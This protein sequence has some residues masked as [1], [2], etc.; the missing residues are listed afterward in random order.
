MCIRDRYYVDSKRAIMLPVGFAA[1]GELVAAK[2]AE[3]GATAVG[4]MT[5]GADPVACSAL[6]AGADVKLFFVR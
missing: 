1:L 3:L 2:A 4:G 5:M 6:A